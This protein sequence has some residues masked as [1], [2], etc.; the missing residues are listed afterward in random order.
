MSWFWDRIRDSIGI[1]IVVAF[2]ARTDDR[3]ANTAFAL[4]SQMFFYTCLDYFIP[5]YSQASSGVLDHF[6]NLDV[7]ERGVLV[8]GQTGAGKSS[9]INSFIKAYDEVAAS[10]RLQEAG[11]SLGAVT[12]ETTEVNVTMRIWAAPDPARP[13][14]VRPMAMLTRFYDTRGF[15]DHHND[16]GGIA[17]TIRAEFS[18]NGPIMH[19]IILVIKVDRMGPLARQLHQLLKRLQK[20]TGVVIALTHCNH[21]DESSIG[22]AKG[23]F[24]NEI[25]KS[26]NLRTFVTC[27]RP[28]DD[29]VGYTADVLK[30]IV[31][32]LRKHNRRWFFPP[33]KRN[34][35][36]ARYK[37]SDLQSMK[38]RQLLNI[39]EDVGIDVAGLVEKEEYVDALAKH[40]GLPTS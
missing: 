21:L 17:N 15:M 40:L 28:Y 26:L 6:N 29:S 10:G 18:A 37:V 34:D 7:Y 24:K 23:T 11:G 19:S 3:F 20:R 30:P 2:F 22:S 16:A 4:A 9:L 35:A 14:V 39:A 32:E 36:A 31:L 33:I 27:L 25:I 8:I 13:Q 38:I 5:T 12:M 1:T